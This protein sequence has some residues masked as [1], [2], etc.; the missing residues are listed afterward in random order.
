M[1]ATESGL[2]AVLLITNSKGDAMAK[3]KEMISEDMLD[4]VEIAAIGV[5]ARDAKKRREELT[6]GVGQQFDV[7]LRV[8]GNLDVAP[9]TTTTTKS[10]PDG[11]MMLAAVFDIIAREMLWE[12]LKKQLAAKAMNADEIGTWIATQISESI[13]S[14]FNE[15][16]EWPESAKEHELRAEAVVLQT[17]TSKTSGRAGAVTGSLEVQTLDLSAVSK[18]TVTKMRKIDI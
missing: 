3:K 11:T 14:D 18:K 5:L 9:D 4:A 8:K 15:K 10:K 1:P 6:P 13:V 16:G 7:T 17:T 12:R 2:A